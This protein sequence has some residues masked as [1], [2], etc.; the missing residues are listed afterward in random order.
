MSGFGAGKKGQG[1]GG[2]L[3]EEQAKCFRFCASRKLATLV[4]T[5][6]QTFSLLSFI[7]AVISTF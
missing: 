4:R 6:I 5:P 2:D 7:C 1:R 3:E